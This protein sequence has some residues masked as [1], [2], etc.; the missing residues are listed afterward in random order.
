MDLV[1]R[2]HLNVMRGVE[3]FP[4][5]LKAQKVCVAG[6]IACHPRIHGLRRVSA[7]YH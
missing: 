4:Q 2:L 7:G 5:D 1:G 6:V 3:K